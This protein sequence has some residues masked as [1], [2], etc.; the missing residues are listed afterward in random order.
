MIIYK[1]PDY[2]GKREWQLKIMIP[3]N[4]SKVDVSEAGRSSPVYKCW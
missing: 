2:R 1:K 3:I 4:S